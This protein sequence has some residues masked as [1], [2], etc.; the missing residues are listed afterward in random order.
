MPV[1]VGLSSL[2]PAFLA[3]I[4]DLPAIDTY[5]SRM[6]DATYRQ[7][8]SQH[9]YRQ[10]QHQRQ[11]RFRVRVRGS[12]RIRGRVRGSGRNQRKGRCRCSVIREVQTVVVVPAGL[13]AYT[14]SKLSPPAPNTFCRSTTY[15]TC[16]SPPPATASL[17]RITRFWEYST[18]GFP[19]VQIPSKLRVSRMQGVSSNE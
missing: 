7:S 4:I 12:G 3:R 10:W 6:I 5:E 15:I 11:W 13:I 18:L 2:V 16:S 1:P 14:R 9:D 8:R 19:Q 17:P